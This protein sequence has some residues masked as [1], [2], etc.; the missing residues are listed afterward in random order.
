MNVLVLTPDRVGST[1]LQRLITIY[2]QFHEFDQPV[3]NLHELTNGIIRY[4]SP[5]FQAEVLGK[6]NDKS[7]WGYHQSLNEVTELLSS[8]PHYKTS[9]LA[10]YHIR[11][12]KDAMDQ[13]VP[14]YQYINDNFFI[15]SA[16]RENLLEH[17][18]SWCIFVSTRHLNV[19]SHQEKFNIFADVYRHGVTVDKI[20][21]YKYLDD[22]V[23]YL[24]WTDRHFHVNS[25]FDY[26]SHI[27]DME[28]YILSLPIFNNQPTKL[29]WQDKF[30]ITL[31]D[32]NR[33][34]YL[35]SDMSKIGLQLTAENKLLLADHRPKESVLSSPAL[36][37]KDAIASLTKKDQLFMRDHALKYKR[38]HLALDE[39][40]QHKILVTGVPIKLQ[41]MVEKRLM[42]QNFDEVV[43]WY[44]QW[45][46]EHGVGQTYSDQDI[47][48]QAEREM[49]HF[50]DVDLL[51][52]QP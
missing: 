37:I 4:Y 12:R 8:V 42:I 38:A 44:N 1:L 51:E 5:V 18:L 45:V 48:K 19:Y 32:W 35:C 43:T 11:N 20:N 16:R 9:R 14:F 27:H 6:G 29:C 52:H 24:A 10:M 26:D 17:A 13:Q 41:T 25:Y 33:C 46:L 2:M 21:L 7:Q 30:D 39:L 36:S 3:I 15:I 40:V 34:H 23:E 31:N 49:L 28:R 50:H 47:V 22:Y